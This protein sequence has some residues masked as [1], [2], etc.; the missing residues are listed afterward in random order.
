MLHTYKYTQPPAPVAPTPHAL[1]AI[2]VSFYSKVW[3]STCM[4]VFV[5]VCVT[6]GHSEQEGSYSFT[7]IFGNNQ[8][9]GL[10]SSKAMRESVWSL[11]LFRTQDSGPFHPYFFILFP[12]G[13]RIRTLIFTRGLAP[14]SKKK[15]MVGRTFSP[16]RPD[17]GIG[18]G[19]VQS[20]MEYVC[21]SHPVIPFYHA[22]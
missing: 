19:L 1:L 6:L 16:K 10:K 9:T 3:G 14:K 8:R 15:K 2:C 13:P 17:W 11:F 22:F 7:I 20:K 5:F 12:S 18:G 21:Q 4:C